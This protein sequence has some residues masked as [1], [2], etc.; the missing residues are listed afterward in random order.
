LGKKINVIKLIYSNLLDFIK[1]KNNKDEL[2]DLINSSSLNE[3]LDS[4]MKGLTAKVWRTYNAS[5]LFQKE[6]DN[7]FYPRSK[8]KSPYFFLHTVEEDLQ[9]IQQ[10]FLLC[11]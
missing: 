11:F 7:R 5:Y 2:F 4:F 1:N 10:N 8:N 3:Y 6:L 9:Q